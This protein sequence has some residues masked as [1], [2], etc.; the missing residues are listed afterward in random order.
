MSSV[1]FFDTAA[2]AGESTRVA[3]TWVRE[4]KLETALPNPPR[5]T[6][7]EVVAHRTREFVQA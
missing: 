6:S 2:Q 7:G 1:G 4:E 5:V 3:S